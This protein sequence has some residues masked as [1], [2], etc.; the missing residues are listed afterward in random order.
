[1]LASDPG[2]ALSLADEGNRRFVGGVLQEEREASAI[3]S[4]AALGRD[5]EARRRG[6]RFLENYPKSSF[7]ER[8][9]LSAKL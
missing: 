9:R 4:L 2:A 6:Q 5:A 7:A 3:R 1:V 8:V